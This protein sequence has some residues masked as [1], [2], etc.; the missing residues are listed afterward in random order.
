MRRLPTSKP[1]V[2]TNDDMFGSRLNQV[3]RFR[4]IDAVFGIDV[5]NWSSR[6]VLVSQRILTANERDRF[7]AS[8]PL[9]QSLLRQPR[10][11]RFPFRWRRS[12]GM[13]LGYGADIELCAVPAGVFNLSGWVALVRELAFLSVFCRSSANIK[14]SRQW[15]ASPRGFILRY[16]GRV[17]TRGRC[18]GDMWYDSCGLGCVPQFN[19][20][21]HLCTVHY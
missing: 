5:V 16:P 21:F 17:F 19:G 10:T 3:V 8:L 12:R 18:A 20:Y 13:D 6:C 2:L 4:I 7:R 11:R 15:D 1:R 9:R 14:H